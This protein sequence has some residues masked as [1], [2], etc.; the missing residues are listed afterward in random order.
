MAVCRVLPGAGRFVGY[1]A[2]QEFLAAHVAGRREA[3]VLLLGCGLSLMGEEMADDGYG[4]VHAVDY[5]PGLLP[6]PRLPACR[7]PLTFARIRY[8]QQQLLLQQLLLLQQQQQQ[9]LLL[10]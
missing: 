9:L 10:L 8:T 1:P 7:C 6:L 2:L 4:C 5:S 3:K